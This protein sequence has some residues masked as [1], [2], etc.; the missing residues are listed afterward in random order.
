MDN[1]N[2]G[3]ETEN[4]ET[5]MEEQN[6]FRELGL[7]QGLLEGLEAMG[8]QVPTP[9][10]AKGIPPVLK[11]QDMI[12]CAQTGTGKTAAYLLPIL[13]L[14]DQ[15]PQPEDKTKVLVI[16]PTRELAQQIDRELEGF[17]YFL[18]VT[19]YPIYGGGD[20]EAFE[21]QKQAL[22]KGVD[23]VIGTP[24]RIWG[25]LNFDY[26]DVS[27]VRCLVLD[28]ADRMLDMGFYEDIMRIVERIGSNTQN[29]LFS[30]TMPKK[31]R[32]MSKKIL[33]NPAEIDIAISQPAEG[34]LQAAH[35]VDNKD[36]AAFIAHLLGDKEKDLNSVMVFCSTKRGVDET[37]RKLK[38]NG[39]DARAVHSDYEQEEREEVLRQFR[40]RNFKVIVATDVLSRGIDIQDIDLILNYDV[41]KDPEDYVHRI[42]RT[43]R[44]EK[45]GIGITL[46]NSDP[47]EQEAFQRIEKLIE[48]E[49]PKSPIPPAV[50]E[51]PEFRPPRKNKGRKGGGPRGKGKGKGR[52]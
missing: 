29:L 52:K 5:K 12:G 30:A 24:G 51:S 1:E 44:A 50:G 47:K 37:T 46:V 48:K 49:I 20:S 15:D 28:E 8:F 13:D 36:K 42:G 22:K 23:I 31:I 19:S 27:A 4:S 2:D 45:E 33:K 35:M 41:P 38:D 40:N 21:S 11:G 16:A 34:I 32:E 18:P 10:Q 3:K 43:A 9:V 39:I 6:T 26:F 7:S 14:L 25:H 17:S